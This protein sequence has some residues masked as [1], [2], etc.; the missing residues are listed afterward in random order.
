M[1]AHTPTQWNN[2]LQIVNTV[3]LA[4]VLILWLTGAFG[5][6]SD[7]LTKDDVKAVVADA[8][9]T[10]PAAQPTQPTQPA[11][12]SATAPSKDEILAFYKTSYVEGPKDA[13]VT[14]FEFSDFQ[15]PFCKR[16]S[17]AGTIDAVLK[18]Y[19]GKVNKVFAHFPLTNIHPLAQKAAE[20]AECVGEQ[21]GD[22]AFYEFGTKIFAEAQPDAATIVKVAGTIKGVDAKKVETCMTEWKYTAKVQAQQAFGA[23]LG[24]TGTPGSI[25]FDHESGEIQK[26]SG[27]VP[28]EA[29]DGPVAAMIK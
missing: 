21:G 4:G 17:T 23:K 19:E 28:A 22:T 24:V 26:V 18:K 9:K 6:G 20:A 29:F 1:T 3:L 25:V 5:G 16:F 7:G 15:C 27:A 10:A 11:Q 8:I 13:K 2:T 12:P 14:I